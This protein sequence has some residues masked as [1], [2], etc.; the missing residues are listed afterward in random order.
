MTFEIPV[1]ILASL[2]MYLVPGYAVLR[3]LWRG[4]SLTTAEEFA[5]AL[6]AGIALPPL[7]LELAHLVGLRWSPWAMAAYLGVALVIILIPN[8]R[9]RSAKL[10][11]APRALVLLIALTVF[12]MGLQLLA[13]KDL[14]AGLWG[15]SLQH[16]MMAQLLIDNGGLFSSWQPY[17]PLTTFTYH[18]GFHANVAFLHW[19]TGIPV[20]QA[21]MLTG[22]I[23]LAA[24][25]PLAFLLVSRL[26]RLARP[27]PLSAGGV[28]AGLWAA[29][30][31]AFYNTL[32]AWL[33]NWGRYTQPTGQVVLVIV[34]VCWLELFEAIENSNKILGLAKYIGLAAIFTACLMLTHYIVTIFGVLCVVALAL[35]YIVRRPSARVMAL[36]VGAGAI[37]AILAGVLALPWLINVAGG[38]LGYNTQAMATGGV[39]AQRVADYAALNPITPFFIKGVLMAL[40]LGGALMALAMRHWRVLFLA[41]WASLVLFTATP[42][43][44]GLPGA[45]VIDSVTAYI[46]LYVFVAPLAGFGLGMAQ[47]WAQ[48]WLAARGSTWRVLPQLATACGMVVAVASA[49]TWQ[50]KMADLNYQLLTPADA[51]AMDWIKSNTPANAKFFVNAFPA[52]GGT[53][54]AGNDGGWWVQFLT[55]RETNLLPLAYGS[56]KAESVEKRFA[57]HTPALAMRGIPLTNLTPVR[58]DLSTP[59]RLNVLKQFGFSYVYIGAH[60]NPS[61][62]QADT[63]DP[64]PLRFSP[65]FRLVY[66]KDGVEIFQLER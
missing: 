23:I 25:A 36:V 46:G 9:A 66:A 39:S 2:A 5:F 31:V 40:A 37:T 13:V 44:F 33:F 58:M 6:G 14:P 3:L 1:A 43:T 64:V 47:E 17:A 26:I 27:Q 35:A 50:P 51:V 10:P 54:L 38:Y 15:D 12:A 4:K 56:E 19:L 65:F 41:A 28:A 22:Q 55:G 18:Y 21:T 45:G 32:P 29:V 60:Q 48:G 53:L 57:F 11:R 30:F 7:L 52:Y 63:I 49:I 24:A 61:S 8:L 62:A 20:I 34:L 16:T 59:A 42:Q